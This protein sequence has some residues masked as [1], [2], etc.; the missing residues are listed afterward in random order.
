MY[1]VHFDSNALTQVQI[2]NIK[3]RRRRKSRKEKGFSSPQK[4]V[5]HYFQHLNKGFGSFF[6]YI[7]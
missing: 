4:I 2:L 5:L 7:L 1:T 6:I 3:R